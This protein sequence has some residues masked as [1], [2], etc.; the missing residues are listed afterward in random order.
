ML[1]PFW[2]YY[3]GKWRAAPR[4]PEPLHDIIIEPFAGAAGYSLRYS[5]RKVILVEK[6]EVIAEMWRWLVRARPSE[7]R[8]IP[9]VD[10]VDDLPR[11]VPQGARSL[12]GFSLNNASTAPCKVLSSGRVEMRSKGR[13]FEGWNEALRDRVA[14]QVE[15]IRHWRIIEGDYSLAPKVEAT[16]F[17]DPPYEVAGH[18]YVHSTVNYSELSAWCRSRRGQVLVCEQAGAS[19]GPFRTFGLTKGAMGR[20]SSEVLWD[21]SCADSRANSRIRPMA[22]KSDQLIEEFLGHV[23]ALADNLRAAVIAE[24]H[25]AFGALAGGKEVGN[26]R[27]KPGPKPKAAKTASAA[28]GGKR[29]RRSPEDIEKQKSQVLQFLKKHKTAKAEVIG[30]ALGLSSTELQI[31]I[32]NLLAEKSISKKGERR[33]TTYSPK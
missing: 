8:L 22:K 18:H 33:A 16:W 17:I 11:W 30:K 10:H 2:R 6:Y 13:N 24:A 31:P 4:Y 21:S 20:Q 19:W 7:V 25:E 28:N 27:K 32:A 5:D 23:A 14:R 9:C 3:G 12:V 26:G 1:K 29:S 15:H